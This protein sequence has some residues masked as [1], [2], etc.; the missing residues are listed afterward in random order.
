M[1]D[2]LIK[3]PKVQE[4][5]KQKKE[6]KLI[7]AYYIVHGKQCSAVLFWQFN[8]LKLITLIIPQYKNISRFC[9]CIFD[10]VLQIM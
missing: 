8:S 2:E 10:F 3:H 4:N 6:I 5:I 1:Q 7:A 9:T